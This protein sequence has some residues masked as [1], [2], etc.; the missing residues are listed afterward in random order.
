MN[1]SKL[2]VLGL[3]LTFSSLAAGAAFADP[4]TVLNP[5]FATL[6]TPAPAFYFQDQGYY[7]QTA[8]PDWTSSN[9]A[10]G[11]S[12]QWYPNSSAFVGAN[13]ATLV[14]YSN[15]S[16][17]SQT[18]GATVVT[19][20]VY[21]LTVDI[22]WRDDPPY[23]NDYTGAANL[24]V[25]GVKYAATPNTT[26]RLGYFTEYTATYTG[27]LADAGDPITIDLVSTDVNNVNYQASFSDVAL[28]Y[29]P[30]VPPIPPTPPSVTPEPSSF[31]LLGLGLVAVVGYSLSKR[32]A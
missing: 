12:G 27:L 4:V 5:N 21:T 10:A 1:L 22:G 24:L 18:V 8:I 7:T 20:D 3:I 6:P 9:P 32:T 15:G 28:N 13:A 29:T 19:G 26:P 31:S 17:L 16:T 23:Q 14:A 30:F 11:Y 2:R 25:D